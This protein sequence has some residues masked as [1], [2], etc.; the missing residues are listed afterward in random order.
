MK[1]VAAFSTGGAAFDMC[2]RSA[3][4]LISDVIKGASGRWPDWYARQRFF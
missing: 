3:P 4:D 1:R 2:L